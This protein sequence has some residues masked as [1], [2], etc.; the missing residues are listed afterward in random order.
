VTK[1]RP[2][3]AADSDRLREWRNDP[4]TVAASL[5]GRSVE[6]EE[7]EAWLARVLDDPEERLFIVEEEGEPV[8]QVRLQRHANGRLEVHIGLAAGARGRGLGRQT[9]ELA[10]KE[11]GGEP[12]NARVLA[13]NERSLRAFAAVGFRERSRDEREVLLERVE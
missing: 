3:T 6:P 13:D 11:A 8:G 7:H 10:W 12:V 9:L 2:A 5:R 1:L 4:E